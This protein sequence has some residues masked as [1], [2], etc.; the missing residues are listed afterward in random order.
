MG[1]VFS[2]FLAVGVPGP[3]VVRTV[4]APVAV[5]VGTSDVLLG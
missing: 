3:D 4:L 5:V 2:M 1:D